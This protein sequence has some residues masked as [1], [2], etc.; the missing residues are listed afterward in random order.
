MKILFSLLALVCLAGCREDVDLLPAETLHALL[1]NE[2]KI[3]FTRFQFRGTGM[4]GPDG[5]F[6]V[7]IPLLGQDE[8]RWWIEEDRICSRWDRFRQGRTLCALVGRLPDGRY[9]SLFPDSGSFLADVKLL[10]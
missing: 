3:E 1:K 6:V 7:A 9:R 10:D 4:L 2:R 5:R 8:G